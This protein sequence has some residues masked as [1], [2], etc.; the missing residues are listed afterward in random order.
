VGIILNH[1]Y[2]IEK[3]INAKDAKGAKGAKEASRANRTLSCVFCVFCVKNNVFARDKL[4]AISKNL[5]N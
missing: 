3:E 5:S 4:S 1:E 2:A